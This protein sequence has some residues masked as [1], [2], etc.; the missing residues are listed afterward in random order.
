MSRNV[1]NISAMGGVMS[2]MA[3]ELAMLGMEAIDPDQRHSQD[4]GT[5]ARRNRYRE[6][7][8][9]KAKAEYEAKAAVFR[10]EK[11]ARDSINFR[12]RLPAGHPDKL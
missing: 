11:A 1:G 7:Q 9:A 12:K 2:L 3:M 6:D 8:A 5:T 4:R 10:A